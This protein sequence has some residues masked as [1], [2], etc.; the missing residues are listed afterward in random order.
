MSNP[1]LPERA[2][3]EWLKRRAK[4]RLRELRQLDPQARLAQA[5]LAI[6]RE[7]GFSS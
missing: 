6:A 7:Q 1:K 4:E 3:L 5:Q 2:S